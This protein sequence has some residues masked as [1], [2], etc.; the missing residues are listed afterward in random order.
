[1]PENNLEKPLIPEIEGKSREQN[2]ESLGIEQLAETEEDTELGEEQRKEEISKLEK[3]N[4]EIMKNIAET[5][6]GL[7]ASEGQKEKPLSVKENEERIKGL[8]KTDRKAEPVL[9]NDQENKDDFKL[10]KKHCSNLMDSIKGL[11]SVFS[12]R[13]SERLN[14]LL[15]DGDLARINTAVSNMEDILSRKEFDKDEFNGEIKNI[16]RSLQKIGEAP[17]QRVMRE[18]VN[19]LTVLISKLK[20]IREDGGDIIRHISKFDLEQTEETRKVLHRLCN[21]SEE[22]WQYIARLRGAA[23]RYRR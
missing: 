14:I 11:K 4:R 1:M 2:R 17:K 19:S 15:E 6:K 16:V 7:P 9:E 18:D 8:L 12:K 22:K 21:I 3:Q 13:N 23:D 20:A 10:E 5:R